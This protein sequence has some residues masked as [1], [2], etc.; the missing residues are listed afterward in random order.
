M[1]INLFV[2]LKRIK[3][4]KGV[5][6]NSLIT[7]AYNKLNKHYRNYISNKNRHP[8]YVTIKTEVIL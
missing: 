8:I 7:N 6:I 5:P 1:S 4:F 2:P 3:I